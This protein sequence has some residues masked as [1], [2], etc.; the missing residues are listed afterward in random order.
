MFLDIWRVSSRITSQREFCNTGQVECLFCAHHF[1]YIPIEIEEKVGRWFKPQS[2]LHSNS[3]DLLWSIQEYTEWKPACSQSTKPSSHSLIC[4]RLI[5]DNIIA[6]AENTYTLP[7]GE[8]SQIISVYEWVDVALQRLDGEVSQRDRQDPRAY[9]ISGLMVTFN[10]FRWYTIDL[11]QNSSTKVIEQASVSTLR[12]SR[13]SR[14]G[15]LGSLRLLQN[16]SESQYG[17]L[18]IHVIPHVR[19]CLFFILVQLHR[20]QRTT[21][22]WN[23][24]D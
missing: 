22:I 24:Y 2:L 16:V 4:S 18:S 5:L 19:I 17:N 21:F 12:K 6:T 11:E 20:M 14:K 23:F 1:K 15:V 3:N 10:I 13:A 7:H 8:R 9:P